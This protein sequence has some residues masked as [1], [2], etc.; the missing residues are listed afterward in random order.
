VFVRTVIGLVG[1]LS[2]LV[3]LPGGAWT[4]TGVEW[5]YLSWAEC[6]S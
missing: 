2:L 6:E 3:L 4:A 1:K 5:G